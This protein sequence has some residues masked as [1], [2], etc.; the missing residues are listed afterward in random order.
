MASGLPP[1]IVEQLMEAERIPIN[2]MKGKKADDEDKLKL[3]GDLEGKLNEIGKNLGELTGTTGFF[4]NKL[5]SGDPN[6]IDGQV[7][8]E[9]VM[10]G[11]WQIE[12]MRLAQKPG[13]M[14]NGFPDRDK[15]QIGV[16]YMRFDTPEGRKDVYINSANNTLDG[17]AKAINA[18]GSGL[19][20]QV[21]N[22]R[23]D[24]DNPFK[25][26][27]TG[28]GTGDDKQVTF[29]TIYMLDG[30]Q[31]V[32]FDE[33]R[34]A[35]NALIK[36]DGF[37]MELGE[38]MVKDVIP[39]VILDLKQAAPGRPI[40]VKVKEDIEAIAGKI[41]S[42]VDAYNGA[43]GFIQNQH[44]LGKDKSGKER[45]GPMGGDGLL[46]SVESSLRRVI[47]N[48]QV[49]I[50]GSI[51]RVNELG[52]EFNRNG[53]LNF[54]QEK[55]QKILATVPFDVAAFFRGDRLNTGFVPTVKRD[56]GQMTSSSNFGPIAIRKKGISDRIKNADQRI[57]AK[58]KQL[59]KKEE[60]LR[61][62][63][64]DLETKMTQ[65]NGQG[66]AVQGFAN[67]IQGNKQ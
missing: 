33:A 7:D 14:S 61:R 66:A 5:I 22:D 17:V 52:I 65:I 34:E 18:S 6:V 54:N 27:V 51:S 21:I 8:P 3:V 47:L 30:D 23:K 45:L 12:V 26:V 41:K 64:T 43:L 49:G 31:D 42:F 53:T 67:S 19:R 29:P 1:N 37:E 55:F 50:E 44:K 13:A 57:E 25:L 20:A 39:G 4:N 2:Q 15:T 11:E 46:R 38:N 62:K 59:E 16:G 9:K 28:L 32:Y 56:I 40:R 10:T 24:R 58:E 35:Q 36:V 63:F 48:Q 60:Q